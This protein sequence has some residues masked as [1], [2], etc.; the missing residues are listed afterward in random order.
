MQKFSIGLSLLLCIFFPLSGVAASTSQ[1]SS[2]FI[3]VVQNNSRILP[4]DGVIYVKREPFELRIKVPRR[5]VILAKIAG[6]D[7]NN[8]SIPNSFF[9]IDDLPA[10][11]LISDSTWYRVPERNKRSVVIARLAQRERVITHRI[12]GFRTLSGSQWELGTYPFSE[13][14]FLNFLVAPIDAKG[15]FSASKTRTQLLSLPIQLDTMSRNDECHLLENM[16]R[17]MGLE[18]QPCNEVLK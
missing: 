12:T 17:N 7:E 4:K 11:A 9:S 13:K 2:F 6:K 5:S 8:P 3:E 15:G 18:P 1:S 10:Y 16:Y 14:L